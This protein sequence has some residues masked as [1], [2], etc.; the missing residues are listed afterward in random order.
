MSEATC[1]AAF[2]INPDVAALIRATLATNSSV[3]P[4]LSPSKTG[5]NALMAGH[6]RLCC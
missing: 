6:P 3:M 4:G 2:G 5:V 1:G